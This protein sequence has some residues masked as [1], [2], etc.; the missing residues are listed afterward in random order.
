MYFIDIVSS[1]EGANI[2]VR[3]KLLISFESIT[4]KKV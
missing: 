3:E 2:G 4:E 1:G